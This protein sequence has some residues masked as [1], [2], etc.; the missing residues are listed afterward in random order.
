MKKHPQK[1]N[2]A[3]VGTSQHS[4]PGKKEVQ[5]ARS[6]REMTELSQTLGFHLWVYDKQVITP[7]DAEAAAKAVKA[8]GADFLLLQCVSYSSGYLAPIFAKI[9]GVRLGLWAIE[10]TMDGVNLSEDGV[11]PLNSFCS[12]NMYAGIIGHYVDSALPFK[13]FFGNR[14]HA[15]FDGRFAVTV[16]ALTA[17]KNMNASRTAL[18]GG[19]APGFNDLYFDERTLLRRFDGLRYERLHEIREITGRAKSFSAHEVEGELQKLKAQTKGANPAALPMLETSARVYLAF[20]EFLE[21]NDYD[22]LA[23]SCWPHFQQ[24]FEKPFSVCSVVG[25]LN[26]DGII[27]ACEGDTLSAIS[28]LMLH[29]LTNDTTMLMD[30]SA[31]DERDETVMMWHC[32]PAASCFANRDGYTISGNYSGAPHTEGQPP[33]CCGVARDMV[34]G[35]RDVTVARLTGEVDK[36]LLAGGTFIDNGKKSFYGSRGWMGNLTLGREPISARD[37]VNTVLVKKFQ[38]HFPIVGGDVSREVMELCAWLGL[39]LVEKTGYQ[40]YLQLN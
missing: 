33:T 4:F 17:L 3:L 16:R 12:I 18:I 1:L 38:H 10:E 24:T 40:D 28:M 9:P 22:A 30:L 37:L 6:V 8:S 15:L 35:A 19:I 11:V 14:G 29:Y 13:W 21:K 32:G 34:F 31:F 7:E 36:L 25:Q 20:R 39:K 2:I 5:F 26:D 27:T 23:V